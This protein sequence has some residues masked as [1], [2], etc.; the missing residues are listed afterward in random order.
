MI[1]PRFDQVAKAMAHPGLS[2]RNALLRVT[3]AGFVASVL[4]TIGPGSRN[5]AVA[6]EQE[7]PGPKNC[8]RHYIYNQQGVLEVIE[9]LCTGTQ[10]CPA[11]WYS[12]LVDWCS[13]CPAFPGGERCCDG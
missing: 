9:R 6:Q 13:A 1:T 3:S 10:P 5:V 2:R 7:L 4:S 8:C 11:D 12:Q